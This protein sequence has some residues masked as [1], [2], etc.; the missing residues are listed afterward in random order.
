MTP[1]RFNKINSVLN[2]RQPD[3]TV[4]M[5]NV[6]K[7]HNLAAIARSCDAVGI[8]EVHAVAYS[9]EI[10]ID[11]KSAVGSE[12]WVALHTH[13]NVPAAF[14][15]LRERGFRILAT[16]F[17]EDATSFRDVDFTG[18]TAIVVGAEMDGI[19]PE[20]IDAA[21]GTL[22]VPMQG[23]VHSLNVSVATAL[24]LFEAQRQRE[25]AGLYDRPRLDAET[26]R[27]L[28]FQWAH[29]RIAPIYDRREEPYP[30]LDAEGN[31]IR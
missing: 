17:S 11:Q 19:S 1:E 28:R 24:I 7:P 6:H 26:L 5:E 20:T 4:M 23:M 29:P 18:P 15:H 3:L 27:R 9:D 2:R 10:A 22:I 16:H 14:D 25:A 31:L 21:D 12:R 30:D 13:A 8:G